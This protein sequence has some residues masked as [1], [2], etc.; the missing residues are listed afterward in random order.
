MA[1]VSLGEVESRFAEI[2]WE[3][4]PLHSR[5]LV[6]LSE[7]ALDWKRSTTYTVL[8][9]LV[10]RGLFKN[11]NGIVSSVI[12]REDYKALQSEHFVER[13]FDGSLPAFIAAFTRRQS[14]SEEE[15]VQ[16]R[17]MIEE[18]AREGQR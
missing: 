4:E 1:V 16:I 17:E 12:S 14:L 8:R 6:K 10:D 2:I 9:K 13:R 5:E 15:V 18:V 11:E 3:H 7:K